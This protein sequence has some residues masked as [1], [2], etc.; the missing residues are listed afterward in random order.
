MK[1]GSKYQFFVPSNLAYGDTGR[2]PVIEPGATLL[3]D[4]ELV[5]I[6]GKK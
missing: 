2:G 6:E 4:V 1:V 5:G 3:F